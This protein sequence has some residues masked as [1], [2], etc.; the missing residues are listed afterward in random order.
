MPAIIS[1]A[2]GKIILF[3]EHAV[4]YGYP[5]IAVPID[6]VQVRVSILP[7]IK[8]T[9]APKS[10]KTSRLDNFLAIFTI[11]QKIYT[12]KSLQVITIIKL[13]NII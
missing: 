5:A 1:K 3:G 11:S 10:T 7:A 13:K 9:A 2:P 6:A 8:A 4:V 12:Y